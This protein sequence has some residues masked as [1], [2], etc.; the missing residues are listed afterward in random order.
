MVAIF[1][2][3][4]WWKDHQDEYKKMCAEHDLAGTEIPHETWVFLA[5]GNVLLDRNRGL[6]LDKIR[7]LGFTE[8][9]PPGHGISVVL[10]RLVAVKRIPSKEVMQKWA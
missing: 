3:Q 10:D 5:A 2:A 1:P 6:S 8:E 9:M 7:A 4:Q